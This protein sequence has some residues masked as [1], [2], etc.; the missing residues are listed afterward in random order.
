MNGGDLQQYW[1]LIAGGLLGILVAVYVI[2]TILRQSAFGQLRRTRSELMV[3]VR[4]QTKAAAKMNACHSRLKKLGAK[5]ETTRPSIL[6]QAIDSFE[7]AKALEKI[8]SDKVLIAENHVRKVIHEEYAPT[9]HERMRR[10]CLPSEKP[11]SRP[12][13]F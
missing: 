6:Q 2:S 5:S 12:F 13:S 9:E 11:D 10:K 8:A 4:E 1:A 3:A 7:D